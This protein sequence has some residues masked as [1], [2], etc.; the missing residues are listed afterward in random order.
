[1]LADD[2]MWY[3]KFE[4]MPKNVMDMFICVVK[5]F[6]LEQCT[7]LLKF[8]MAYNCLSDLLM[9]DIQI[10]EVNAVNIINVNFIIV[11]LTC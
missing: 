6:T 2:N 4:N 7:M 9:K 3:T 11:S 8:I 10:M 5:D 1:M